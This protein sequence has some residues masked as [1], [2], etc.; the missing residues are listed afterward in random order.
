MKYALK[1]AAA[2]AK[3]ESEYNARTTSSDFARAD[4][5]PIGSAAALAS[6]VR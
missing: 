4:D 5:R 3:K 2:D 6:A 1:A